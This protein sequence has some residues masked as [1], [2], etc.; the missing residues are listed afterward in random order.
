M[1]TRTSSMMCPSGA[2]TVPNLIVYP[3]ASEMEPRL[4]DITLSAISNAAGPLTLMTEIAPVPGTVAG[5]YIVSSFLIYMPMK[6]LVAKIQLYLLK[7]LKKHYL[8]KDLLQPKR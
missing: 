6:N 2:E 5:A 8:R 4:Q 3:S 1:L 7:S